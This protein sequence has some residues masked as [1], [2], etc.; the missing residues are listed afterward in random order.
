MISIQNIIS[1]YH[2][3]GI[4]QLR[5]LVYQLMKNAVIILNLGL[6]VKEEVLVPQIYSLANLNLNLALFL[7]KRTFTTNELGCLLLTSFNED[8]FRSEVL[9]KHWNSAWNTQRT[10]FLPPPCFFFFLRK[11]CFRII[12]QLAIPHTLIYFTITSY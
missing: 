10:R 12:N 7:R 9:A 3:L 5:I 4:L 11:I 6:T 8:G 2:V 1:S